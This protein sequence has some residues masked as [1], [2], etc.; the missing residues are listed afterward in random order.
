MNS[1]HF[2]QL[3]S[4]FHGRT[5]PEQGNLVGYGALIDSLKLAV[6]MPN[7]LAIISMKHKR[8]E[9]GNWLVFTPRHQPQETIYD[10]LVFA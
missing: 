4:T 3:V 8:Y 6:P 2:S 7:K 9:A 1:K 10:H 5:A